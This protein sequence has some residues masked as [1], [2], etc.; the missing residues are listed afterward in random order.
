M[1]ADRDN[2]PA[3][4]VDMEDDLTEIDASIRAFLRLVARY[5][6]HLEPN[7]EPE[8]M[9]YYVGYV[10]SGKLLSDYRSLREKWDR[11]FDLTRPDNVERL[12]GCN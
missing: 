4:V 3:I 11:L 10:L 7:G 2:V 5:G 12:P 1:S 6:Q 9:P 8:G